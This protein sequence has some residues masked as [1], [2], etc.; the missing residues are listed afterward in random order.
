MSDEIEDP[1]K[2]LDITTKRPYSPRT[3]TA[4][5]VVANTE[6]ELLWCSACETSDMKIIGSSI[7][8]SS[9]L[10]KIRG[11]LVLDPHDL[12]LEPPEDGV[13]EDD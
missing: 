10:G 9:C 7:Y 12:G 8:C 5:E 2:V 1:R 4:D 6:D 13:H 11:F 3:P